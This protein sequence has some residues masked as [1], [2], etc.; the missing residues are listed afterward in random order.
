[1]ICLSVRQPYAGLI[2]SGIKTIELRSWK[3]KYRGTLYVHAS[4]EPDRAACRRLD[5]DRQ[6]LECGAI[7][8]AVRL[9]DVVW[10]GDDDLDAR[11]DAHMS[12]AGVPA[13]YGFLL[14][15]PRRLPEPIPA[16]GRL[17]L[18]RFGSRGGLFSGTQGRPPY[19]VPQK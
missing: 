6:G 14:D 1:M 3:T 11:I 8:G 19:P 7:I 16:K 17:G 12:G 5:I 10:Y 13:C 9:R 2:A 18:W 4:R 15:C